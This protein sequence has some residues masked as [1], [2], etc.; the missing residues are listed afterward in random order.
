MANYFA[1][2]CCFEIAGFGD[3]VRIVAENAVAV[4]Q[5][6]DRSANYLKVARWAAHEIEY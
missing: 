5:K 2:T 1:P 3:S 4:D 6:M